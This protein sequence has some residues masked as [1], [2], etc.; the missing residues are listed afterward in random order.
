MNHENHERI[1]YDCPECE[2]EVTASAALAGMGGTS[3]SKAEL[4]EGLALRGQTDSWKLT[5]FDLHAEIK[6]QQTLGSYVVAPLSM[7]RCS[8]CG[9]LL[10]YF[11]A[12]KTHGATDAQ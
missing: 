8:E 3:Y 4:S 9:D 6:E 12:C 7:L 11:G 10:D 5:P 2:A 1:D